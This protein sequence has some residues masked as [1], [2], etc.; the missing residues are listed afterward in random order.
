MDVNVSSLRPPPAAESTSSR[1]MYVK[2]EFQLR[3]SFEANH[4]LRFKFETNGGQQLKE[5]TVNYQTT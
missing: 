3:L 5:A 4:V 1:D 2:I